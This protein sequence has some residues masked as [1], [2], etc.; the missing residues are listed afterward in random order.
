MGDC[1]SKPDTGT[2]KV[3]PIRS[4]QGSLQVDSRSSSLRE[5][6][7]NE[8]SALQSRSAVKVVVVVR[9]LLEAEKQ[10]GG[11]PCVEVPESCVVQLPAKRGGTE[12]YRYDFDRVY[13]MSSPGRQ[14]FAEVVQPLLDRFMQGFNTTVFAYGQTGS[15][16]TYTM[17]TAAT[18]RQ[19]SSGEEG[20]GIIPRSMR[21]IF[22]SLTTIQDAYD[23]S[24]KVSFIE[25]YQDDIRDLLDAD[26]Y[27]P[28]NVRESPERGTFLENVQEVEVRSVAEVARLLEAGNL[29]RAVAAHNLNEHSS[30]SHAICTLHLEQR[31]RP[32]APPA[33]KDIPRFLR[34]K[35]HLVDLAGSERAKET[36]T[37]GQQ[38]AEGVNIN[39]GLS[40]LGNVIGALSEGASRKHIPYRD[41]KLTRLLQDSLGGNS[42]TLMVACVSPANFNYEP[43][44]STLRYA[45]RAR[46]I[47][48]RVKQNNKYTPEDEI[49]Y[50]RQQLEERSAMV[51]KL[52]SQLDMALRMLK[53]AASPSGVK[54][55]LPAHLSSPVSPG[56]ITSARLSY[57][58]SGVY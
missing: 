54:L 8:Y 31:R 58:G 25:I 45:S 40:A 38:F 46:S 17:G 49:A 9:P 22:D 19:M 35:L 39:K 28:I 5:K 18:F 26:S 51:S 37:T 55:V 3:T 7:G 41:S 44:L 4:D 36:G 27:M 23:V 15:G 2:K 33:A 29:H 57:S 12:G 32:H 16:K 50:L 11:S 53:G 30:R 14:M 10:K 42:E 13:K 21:Y 48:N 6:D 43:T 20:D 52:Q 56:G 24:I 1:A 34:A 47:Q